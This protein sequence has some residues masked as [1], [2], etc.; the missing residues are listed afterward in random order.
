MALVSTTMFVIIGVIVVF[1]VV[2]IIVIV[3]I[4]VIGVIVVDIAIVTNYNNKMTMPIFV[5]CCIVTITITTTMV[6]SVVFVQPTTIMAIGWLTHNQQTNK[7]E[8]VMSMLGNG[9]VVNNAASQPTNRPQ[10]Q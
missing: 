10:Q 2:I 1:V 3:V 6:I 4:V 9:I 7:R 5:V 8:T